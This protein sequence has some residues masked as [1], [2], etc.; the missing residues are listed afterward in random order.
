MSSL[1]PD[2]E[3][4]EKDQRSNSFLNRIFRKSA[5][6]AMETLSEEPREEETKQPNFVIQLQQK[7]A[8]IR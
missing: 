6:N 3:P 4:Q 8:Q 7:I 1:I 2:L 5:A